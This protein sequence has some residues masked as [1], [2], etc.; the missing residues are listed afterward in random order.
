M[1]LERVL[2]KQHF[3]PKSNALQT[4]SLGSLS[5]F[6]SLMS[7]VR[8]LLFVAWMKS[9]SNQIGTMETLVCLYFSFSYPVGFVHAPQATHFLC[10]C[11]L[12]TQ[13]GGGMVLSFPSSY[14]GSGPVSTVHPQKISGIS[15]TPKIFE[16]LAT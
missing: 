11:E 8:E 7:C 1:T 3:E 2:N 9:K 15:S 12:W 10:I 4:E 14:L 16:I 6:V 5:P 13:G